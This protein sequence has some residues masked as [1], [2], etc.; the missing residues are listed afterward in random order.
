[1]KAKIAYIKRPVK[2]PGNI[3]IF[4]NPVSVFRYASGLDIYR[5]TDER[6][7]DLSLYFDL[8]IFM[9]V[10]NEVFD[11]ALAS[12]KRIMSIAYNPVLAKV[13]NI[14][15]M[16]YFSGFNDFWK[17]ITFFH[18]DETTNKIKFASSDDTLDYKLFPLLDM[19]NYP[20]I[21]KYEIPYNALLTRDYLSTFFA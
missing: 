20:Y 15:I 12:G 21:K 8:K 10:F 6:L 3:I 11:T 16:K 4:E 13:V 17:Q 1:M 5:I 19:L 18:D 14:F 9:E 2:F 7:A